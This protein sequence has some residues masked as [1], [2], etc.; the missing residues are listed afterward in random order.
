MNIVGARSANGYCLPT[1]PSDVNRNRNNSAAHK[2][3]TW[4]VFV[5]CCRTQPAC[6]S[7]CALH[8]NVTSEAL[9]N[10][11]LLKKKC[12]FSRQDWA[13]IWLRI[14]HNRIKQ[15]LWSI[16]SNVEIRIHWDQKDDMTW[17]HMR[18]LFRE[19]VSLEIRTI[20]LWASAIHISFIEKNTK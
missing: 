12:L 11:M 16:Y 3:L 4:A 2:F 8:E 17:I 7:A 18:V 14:R 9:S 10:A 1:L 6:S 19:I 13:Y 5:G 20:S 15:N